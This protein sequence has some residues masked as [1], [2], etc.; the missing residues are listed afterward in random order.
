MQACMRRPVKLVKYHALMQ[1]KDACARPCSGNA[2]QSAK[3][4]RRLI[5]DSTEIKADQKLNVPTTV[6][7]GR[8]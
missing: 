6:Q 1:A 5:N 2:M 4:E 7:D 3:A 8:Q